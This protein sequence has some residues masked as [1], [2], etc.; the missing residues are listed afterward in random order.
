MCFCTAEKVVA[1]VGAGLGRSPVLEVGELWVGPPWP[2]EAVRSLRM[3]AVVL[4][5]QKE[6]ARCFYPDIH[7]SSRS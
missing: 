1:V 7:D 3:H 4:Q 2:T 6:I 5:V